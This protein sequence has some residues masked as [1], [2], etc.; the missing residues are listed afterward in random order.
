MEYGKGIAIDAHALVW[1]YH[2]DSN[3]KLSIRVLRAILEAEEKGIIY[4]STVV[5]MEVL[6]LLEKGKYPI[7]FD[8]FLNDIE[9][10]EAYKIVPLTTEVIKAMKNFPDLELHDRAIVATALITDS[11][12]I[13][14]DIEI[15]KTYSRVIW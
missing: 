11:D 14:K 10:D 5:L 6:R 4:V 7:I 3:I 9:D 1:Y 12:L 15:S 8:D 13:T 2:E